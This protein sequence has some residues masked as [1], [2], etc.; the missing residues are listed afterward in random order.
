M[1]THVPISPPSCAS[2]PPS[3]SHPSRW[4]QST[5]PNSLCYG[6]ASHQPTILHS[7]VYI[8]QCY[9][10]FT[11]ASPSHPVSSGP[12]SMS[13]SLFLPCNQVHQYHFLFLF[14]RFHIYAL[15]YGICFS[16]S[17]LLH[18]YFTLGPSTSLQIISFLFIA[19]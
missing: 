7:E 12:F 19:E 10:H 14:F 16:L 13:T 17:D 5:E 2:L 18:S 11:Q 8:C 1:H 4:S 15:A 9:S 6:A 3:L